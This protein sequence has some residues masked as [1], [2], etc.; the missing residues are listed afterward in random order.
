MSTEVLNNTVRS[1]VRITRLH[2]LTPNNAHLRAQTLEGIGHK[3]KLA[4]IKSMKGVDCFLGPDRSI[5]DRPSH[6][7]DLKF[8][9]HG[10]ERSKNVGE[11]NDSIR[12]EGMPWLE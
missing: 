5:Y 2:A 12:V 6:I 9:S 11:E 1:K 3:L 8:D 10:G 4:A 7:I